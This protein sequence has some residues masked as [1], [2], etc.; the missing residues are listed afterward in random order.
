[1]VS[2]MWRV[3][4]KAR[5]WGR[6]SAFLFL[7]TTGPGMC[8][9]ILQPS[10]LSSSCSQRPTSRTGGGTGLRHLP[11]LPDRV[12]LILPSPATLATAPAAAQIF[13]LTGVDD[14]SSLADAFTDLQDASAAAVSGDEIWVAAGTCK[15][16]S[17]TDRE[18][19][20]QLKNDVGLYGS[21]TGGGRSAP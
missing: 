9:E 4:Q 7:G 14:C 16:T 6:R 10:T 1:M 8:I 12:G 2:I 17:V 5:K 19:T 15:L 3:Y 11:N 21:F 20:F 13:V 18:A